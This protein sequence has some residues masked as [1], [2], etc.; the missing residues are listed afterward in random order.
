[1]KYAGS[2]A[3]FSHLRTRYM[4]QAFSI[5]LTKHWD[6]L[7]ASIA[8]CTFIYY[9]TLHS[10]IG[11]SP[12][13]VMYQTTAINIKNHFSFTDFNNLP[14]VDFPLGYPC[15]LALS[16][17]VSGLP[18]LQIVPFLNACLF[19]GVII[20]TSV[21]IS[22]YR[23]TSPLYKILIL[24]ALACSP[25]LLEVY[26]M[27]WSETLFIF[28]ALLFV[29]AWRSYLNS[30]SYAKLLLA[31]SVAALAFVT[32]YAGITLLAT[33]GYLLLFDGELTLGKK[34]KQIAIFSIAGGS[35]VAINLFR[36]I[37]VT[38]HATGFR[39]KAIRTLSDNL[40][41][42]GGTLADWLPFIKGH[43]T[44]ATVVFILVLLFGVT[45]LFTRSFQQQYYAAYETIIACLFVVYAFFMIVVATISRFENLSSRL[46]SP[47][48]IPLLLVGSSWV[49]NSIRH[50][51][52]I[53]KILLI[54]PILLFYSGF[55]Y[56]QYQLNAE[57]WEGIG[58]AGIPGYTEDSWVHSPVMAYIKKNKTVF[59]GPVYSNANDAVYFFSGVHALALPHKEILSEIDV[60]LQ[61]PSFWLVWLNDGENSDLVNL[62]FIKQHRKIVSTK[63]LDDGAIYFFTDITATISH[64]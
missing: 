41:Q 30:H 6:A 9:Y 19:S 10:G 63:I 54:I 39:E 44:L 58:D 25:C 5:F 46:L 40:N 49:V 38:G 8:A 16:A 36:N 21:I 62:E 61:K 34:I 23:Q 43:E 53:R 42:I 17:W 1:M 32:R 56:N 33:G 26:S 4:K 35:L 57:A 12:D 55:Q 27:L 7:L 15:F 45:Q 13:S 28:L 14:T 31:A 51:Y 18:V 52:R 64:R 48:Y 2:M 29:V 3:N 60:L 50:S 24:A 47:L 20:L 37:H 11:I 22:G 59:S